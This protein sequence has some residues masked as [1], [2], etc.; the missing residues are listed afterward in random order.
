MTELLSS[1]VSPPAFLPTL[2]LF[3]PI[4]G[5]PWPGLPT[6]HTLAFFR[7][8]AHAFLGFLGCLE[9]FCCHLSSSNSAC[10]TYILYF[11]PRKAILKDFLLFTPLPEAVKL[12]GLAVYILLVLVS[13]MITSY[14]C[15]VLL[16]LENF[17]SIILFGSLLF[18]LIH[19]CHGSLP[20]HGQL[21]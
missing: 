5:N 13:N 11:I 12:K 7:N 16:C 9:Y 10:V 18:L 19:F 3:V 6:A 1:T 21:N 17:A 2:Q 15:S 14:T 20:K 4:P 8:F